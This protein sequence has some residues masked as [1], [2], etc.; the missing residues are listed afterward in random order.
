MSGLAL[1]HIAIAARQPAKLAAFYESLFD[2]ERVLGKRISSGSVWLRMALPARGADESEPAATAPILMFEQAD[3]SI[4]K[5]PPGQSKAG[6]GEATAFV[7]EF[8]AKAP[9]LHLLA[10]RIVPESRAA[11][12]GKLR[13]AG[14]A[15]ENESPHTIYFRDPEGNRVGLSHYPLGID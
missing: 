7:A 14:V 3:D 2:F 12:V 10:F 6:D 1:H 4:S 8:A 11:W 5:T 15:I 13:A 9:G